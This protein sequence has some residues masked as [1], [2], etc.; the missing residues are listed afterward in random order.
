[1]SLPLAERRDVRSLRN[2][3]AGTGSLARN[4]TAYLAHLNE[5]V[6]LTPV[7]DSAVTQLETWVEGKLIQ[8]WRG[9]R[10]VR[11]HASLLTFN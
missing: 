11:K 1:M 9:F 6:S 10:R 2:W 8:Y 4:E 3:V 7:V 5:L